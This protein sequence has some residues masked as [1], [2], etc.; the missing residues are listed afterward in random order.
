MKRLRTNGNFLTKVNQKN[1]E[2]AE[3]L[4]MKYNNKQQLPTSRNNTYKIVSLNQYRN[5]VQEKYNSKVTAKRSRETTQESRTQ[6]GKE[7][8]VWQ[9]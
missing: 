9:Q 7:H 1:F 8:I 6:K 3:D 2:E 5:K 4:N